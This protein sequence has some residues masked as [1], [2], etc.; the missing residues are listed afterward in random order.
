[1][2]MK[3]RVFLLAGSIALNVASLAA[4]ALRPALAP[5]AVRDFFARHFHRGRDVPAA[6]PKPAAAKPFAR[7]TIWPTLDAAGDLKTLAARLRNAGFPAEIIRAMVLAELSARYD[8]KM[9]AMFEPDPGTPFW[10]LGANFFVAGDKRMEEYGQ[11]QR[12]RAKLQR[13]LFADPFFATDDV[14]AA[15]RRQFGNLP[16]QKIDLLQRI[17]DDYAEMG[18]AIRSATNGI[19]L[20]E[21]RE[22]LAL[23]MRERGA[24][25]AG[26]L[27][28]E[29]LADY[30]MRSSPL[31]NMLTRQL[32]SF[33]ASEA[34]FRA[35]FQAQQAYSDKLGTTA[36][37]SGANFEDR[38]TAQ[39]QLSDRLKTSLGDARYADYVRETDRTYQQLSRLAQRENLPPET[40]TRAFNIRDTVAQESGRIADDPALSTEQ[41]RAA[42]QTL[43]ESTRSQLLSMLGPAAG[44]TYVK[45]VDSQWLNAVQRGSAV[46]FGGGMGGSMTYSMGGGSSGMPVS[47][48]F[49]LSPTF[50]NVGRPPPPPPPR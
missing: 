50:R 43:A 5:P 39:Q 10:K 21:D 32:A 17:E 26:V 31:T 30:E 33:N 11:L 49:G 3:L 25:L 9:R 47:V 23:L 14:T 8:A 16:R 36:M 1:M 13:E 12:E 34:E 18:T 7:K 38:R 29:E 24:D 27:S 22:K 48:S 35:I 44:P 41:K 40:A 37:S 2:T 19:L 42:L 45:I 28:T 6:T 15:Q 46:S 20:A 4:F